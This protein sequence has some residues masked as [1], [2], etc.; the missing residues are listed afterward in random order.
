[1]EK[2]TLRHGSKLKICYLVER[3]RHPELQHFM[4]QLKKDDLSTHKKA[5]KFLEKL[6]DNPKDFKVLGKFKKLQHEE[7]LWE[8]KIS[9][10]TRFFLFYSSKNEVCITHGYR[11]QR[12]SDK[13]LTQEI[14]KA[15]TIKRRYY[16][17]QQ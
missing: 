9:N 4:E 14:E 7:G 11:K 2:R 15:A 13:R 10:E 3:D 12:K 17:E 1:M 5:L 8:L 16:Y 6:K